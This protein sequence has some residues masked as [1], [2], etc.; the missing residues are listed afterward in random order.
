MKIF[1][2]KMFFIASFLV[3]CENST[4]GPKDV[5]PVQKD[6]FENMYVE[7]SAN[8]KKVILDSVVIITTSCIPKFNGTGIISLSG[9][10]MSDSSIHII[11]QPILDTLISDAGMSKILEFPVTFIANEKL[12]INWEITFKTP[13]SYAFSSTAIFDSIAVTDSSELYNYEPVDDQRHY[14]Y[15][16][17]NSHPPLFFTYP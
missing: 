2:L 11:T 4:D 10:G 5:L 13:T 9:H 7:L 12:I 17:A 6:T 15:W 16:Y 8:T 3:S 14:R 1:I